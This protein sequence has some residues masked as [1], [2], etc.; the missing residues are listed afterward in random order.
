M[1]IRLYG[2]LEF[3]GVISKFLEEAPKFLSIYKASCAMSHAPVT[4]AGGIELTFGG[5]GQNM[6]IKQIID[7]FCACL[8]PGGEIL[9][10]GDADVI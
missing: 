1:L 7:D 9:Y 3:N 2:A 10:I 4:L 8:I 5:G 6:F